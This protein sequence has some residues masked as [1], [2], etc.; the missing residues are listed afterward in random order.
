MKEFNIIIKN[1]HNLLEEEFE[2]IFN[3]LKKSDEEFQPSLTSRYPVSEEGYCG[4]K[5]YLLSKFVYNTHFFLTYH[6]VQV[7]AFMIVNQ[8][9]LEDHTPIAQIGTTC[10]DKDFRSY[11]LG[12]QLYQFADDN[13]PSL[14]NTRTI[15]RNTWSTNYK[16]IARYERFGYTEFKRV[17]KPDL[18]GVDSVYFYKDFDYIGNEEQEGA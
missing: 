2:A 5:Q 10:V 6:E 3:I 4:V 18:E 15:V 13:L 8:G 7:V 17:P 9:F 12:V 16:Q 14:M 11:G 1:I